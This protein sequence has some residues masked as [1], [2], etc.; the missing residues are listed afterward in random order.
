[1]ASLM[2]LSFDLK[3]PGS[4]YPSVERFSGLSVFILDLES[5]YLHQGDYE[6][7]SKTKNSVAYLLRLHGGVSSQNP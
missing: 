5:F 7:H 6:I 4:S 2:C 1:M 3:G